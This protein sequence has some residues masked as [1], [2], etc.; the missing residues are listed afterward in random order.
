MTVSNKMVKIWLSLLAVLIIAGCTT[1]KKRG[2]LTKVQRFY[3]NTVSEFNGYFNANILYEESKLKLKDQVQDNYN[4]VLP[5]YKFTTA[6]NPQAV[7]E[8]LDEAIKK[9]SIV[10]SLHRESDWT[11][12]C[13]LLM[14][15]SLFLKQ[16]YESAEE[17]L[18]YLVGEFNPEALAKKKSRKAKKAEKKEDR[19]TK[20][21]KKK[22]KEKEKSKK[23]KKKEIAKKKKDRVKDAKARKKARAKGKKLPPKPTNEEKMAKLAEEKRLA[24]AAE[25][26]AAEKE[27]EEAE[28]K[29]E[30]PK[31]KYVLKHRPCYQEGVLWLAKTYVERDNFIRAQ[32]LFEEL[33]ND[34]YTFKDIKE[35]LAPAMAYFYLEQKKYD[36]AVQPLNEAIKLVDDK[37][38]KGRYAFILAQIHQNA[39]R[40]LEAL[41]NFELA[42]K[43]SNNYCLLYTSP[44]PRDRTRSRMPSSA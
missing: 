34:P 15:K 7:A 21:K 6:D 19:S 8:D 27:A 10:V 39:G 13:Y 1:Q 11:D 16:D 35:Q 25:K 32:F 18:A 37:N 38:D 43:Y 44:S 20:G 14:G 28:I 23:D 31:T 26:E 29:P 41:A 33:A 22:K 36:E 42:K 30:K 17:A 4:K 3:K 9:V 40:N 24:E 2:E 12:D 5:V